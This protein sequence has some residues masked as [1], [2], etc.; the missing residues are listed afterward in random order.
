VVSETRAARRP[1]R[2][3]AQPRPQALRSIPAPAAGR[4]GDARGLDELLHHRIRLG[5]VSALA[6]TDELSFVELRA[7]LKVTDG[8]LS[9]HARKLEDAGY[10]RC[11]KSF[12]E[13]RPR[14]AYRLADSGLKALERYLDHMQAVIAATRTTLDR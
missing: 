2:A 1:P 5:I 10:I 3:T 13:R 6:G 8:N 9:V 7:V 14:T 4:A 11:T 12:A